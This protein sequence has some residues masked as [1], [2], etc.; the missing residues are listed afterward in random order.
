VQ[1]LGLLHLSVTKEFRTQ[2]GFFSM[3]ICIHPTPAQQQALRPRWQGSGELRL[4]VECNGP[5]HYTSNTRA[6]LGS[7]YLRDRGLQH[8]GWTVR[9][10]RVVA[11]SADE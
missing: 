10:L 2:S 4:A 6:K 3:D 8:E 5:A 7:S 11:G 1:T 9:V